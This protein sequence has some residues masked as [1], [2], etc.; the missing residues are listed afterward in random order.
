MNHAD[1][2]PDQDTSAREEPRQASPNGAR[3]YVDTFY[4]HWLIALIPVVILPVAAVGV[5]LMS[6]KYP[7]AV[8]NVW[9]SQTST[10]Q[11]G[12]VA[13][14]TSPAGNAQAELNQLLQTQRFD[15]SVARQS[16]LYWQLA[17]AQPYRDIWIV[18]DMS[19]NVKVTT[20]GS[21]LL[22]ISYS[23]KN[24]VLGTQLLQSILNVAPNQIKALYQQQSVDRVKF[25]TRQ[26]QKVKGQL[27]QANSALAVY[28]LAHHIG[29][30]Q[31]AQQTLV[32]PNL[33]ALYEAQQTAQNNEQAAK[34][35]YDQAQPAGGL[36]SALTVI[37][38][39]TVVPATASKKALILNAGIGLIIGLLLSFAFIVAATLRDQSMRYAGEVLGVT[40]LPVLASIPY[41]QKMVPGGRR[42]APTAEGLEQAS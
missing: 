8:T 9:V 10:S 26:L 29:A 6:H 12:Y 3:R 11:L 1:T 27:S 15:L 7:T 24:A 40:G 22:A 41:S 23:P 34:T 35:Q 28:L 17:N 37:D 38:A 5:G 36:G 21:N 32:D 18:K 14:F 19:K 4:R 13:P 30:N 31:V 33:A 39:P 25:L 2:E 16:P 42:T 20:G